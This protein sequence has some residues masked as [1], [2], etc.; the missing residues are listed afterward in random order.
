MTDY[1]CKSILCYMERK[2]DTNEPTKDFPIV[3]GANGTDK[4]LIDVGRAQ[5]KINSSDFT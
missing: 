4:L 3:T 5:L 2:F 1:A